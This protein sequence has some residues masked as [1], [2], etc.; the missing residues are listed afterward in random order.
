M[1]YPR[2]ESDRIKREE[3][4]KQQLFE[5]SP[6][7]ELVGKYINGQTKVTYRC[8]ECGEGNQI[9]NPRNLV[10]GFTKCIKCD[11]TRRVLVGHNDYATTHPNHTLLLKNPEE[12]KTFTF[13]SKRMVEL[14][15]PICGTEKTKR[16]VDVTKNAMSCPKCGDGFSYPNK[17]MW[18]L[19]S[20]LKIN[21]DSEITFDWSQNKRYDFLVGNNLI[22]MDGSFHKGSKYQTY[23]E[24]KEI[25][26]LK[27]RLA[28]NNGYTIIRIE[29]YQSDF[30][31]IKNNIL[32]SLLSKILE[33][34]KVDWIELEKELITNNLVKVASSIFNEYLGIKNISDMAKLMNVTT[35]KF[36]AFLRTATRIGLANYNA[37]DSKNGVYDVDRGLDFGKECICLN[38]SKI[39]PSCKEAEREY[40]LPKDSVGRIC[41]GE[42]LSVHNLSFDFIETTEEIQNKKKLMQINK[43]KP[44][45]HMRKVICVETGKEYDSTSEASR[46]LGMNNNYVSGIIRKG[47]KTPEGHTFKYV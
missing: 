9:T 44:S 37:T 23:E 27:D 26:D 11:G 20:Q 45:H 29:C 21:F 40:D 17:F 28:I 16:V 36:S 15:C 46:Q 33:L 41:R 19:L 7:L 43:D 31:Y 10:Y 1:D 24:V 22:E 35:A 42:R 30:E 3:K 4:F 34:D 14:K 38:D 47:R 2:K 6:N 18:N 5:M 12:A 39:Y 8:K 13:S 25:D 32:N